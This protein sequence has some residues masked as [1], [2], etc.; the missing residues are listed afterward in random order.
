M[1]LLAL[2]LLFVVLLQDV[3]ALLVGLKLLAH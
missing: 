1:L 2:S 3:L